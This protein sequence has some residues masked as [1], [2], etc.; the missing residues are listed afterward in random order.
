M[1]IAIIGT[2]YW[3]EFQAAAWKAVG[4]K[5]AAVWNRTEQKAAAFAQKYGGK[6]YA[7]LRKLLSASGF[8]IVDVITSADAHLD[9]M[10][11]CAEYSRPAICQ[12]PMA[13]KF[14]DCL[15]ITALFKKK[16]LW[17]AVH[18]NF[19][20]QP[21]VAE[22]KRLLDGGAIGKVRR[23]DIQLKSPDRAIIAKQPALA[24]TDNMPLRDMGPHIFDVA[25]YLFGEAETVFAKSVN[26]YPEFKAH[27]SAAA[28]LF[29]RSGCLV[30]CSLT[31]TFVYKCLTEGDGGTLVL[32]ADN[33]ISLL[34]GAG[35]ERLYTPDYKR[36]EYIP[37]DDWQTHGAH[38]FH[39]VPLC[40]KSLSDA[41]LKGEPAPTSLVDNLET[42]RIMFAAIE[43][44]KTDKNIKIK[45]ITK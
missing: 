44:N 29:M 24:V 15:E 27:D 16:G 38:V 5:I 8:D 35:S 33:T 12:K 41:F 2:G 9:I 25:R 10:R 19:R 3:A 20:Y 45:D 32:Y 22:Y 39:A 13:E 4:A 18:E 14:A 30:E 1:R 7:D 40:L 43:S 37:Q 34:R 23:A 21:Q 26:T 42:M 31:H 36:L 11:L 28:V 17:G 6:V